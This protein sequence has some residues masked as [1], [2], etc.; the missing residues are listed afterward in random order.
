MFVIMDTSE[1][2]QQFRPYIP[3][4]LEAILESPVKRGNQ[5]IPYEQV[6]A[7]LE[8][9]TIATST[10]LGFENTSR[11]SCGAYSHSANLMLQVIT[12]L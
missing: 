2:P 12:R 11:F 3:L 1:V 7:E 6:V 10:R 5:L 9:D 8:A 4:L